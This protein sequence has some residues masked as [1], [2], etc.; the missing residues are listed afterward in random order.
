VRPSGHHYA[1][2]ASWRLEAAEAITADFGLR[3]DRTTLVDENGDALSPRVGLL[4]Q[5]GGAT[6]VRAGWGRFFQAQGIDE[7]AVSDGDPRFYPGQHAQHWVASIEHRLRDGL[8]LRLEAY[9]KQ[10]DDLRP[11]YENLLNPLVVLPEIKPDRIRIEP[12]SAKADGVEV[13]LDYERGPYVGWLAYSWSSVTDRVD[14]RDVRRSWDQTHYLTG[15]ASYGSERW[16]LSL[17]VA[18]HSGWPTTGVSLRTLEPIALVDTG[19]RNAERL[20]TYLRFDA[21]IA[22]HFEVGADQRL[23]VFVDV[24]NL[25]N[26]RNDCCTEYQIETEEPVPFLDVAPLESL[27]TV[28]SIGVIWEF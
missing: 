18:W 11:R 14:G 24:S 12:G 6:R 19:P 10:Y 20:G 2:Y 27:H 17:T 4:W 3:W 28:P 9:H 23:T 22:R 5:A 13:S 25:T 26:R 8:D 16:D 1:A 21:R 7:L 15:G